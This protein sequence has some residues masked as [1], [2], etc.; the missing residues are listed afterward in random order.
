MSDTHYLAFR[1]V[2]RTFE[3]TTSFGHVVH[4]LT[5]AGEATRVTGATVT[6]QFLDVLRTH[7]VLGRS[8]VA[9]DATPGN[10]PIVLLSDRLWRSRFGADPQVLHR[11]IV[12]DGTA[13]TVVGILPRGFSFPADAEFWT[14][15][16]IRPDPNLT[17]TRPVIGRLRSGVTHEQAA[18]AFRA[19]VAQLPDPGSRENWRAEVLRLR[20]AVVGDTRQVLFLFAGAV[21]CVLLITWANVANLLLMRTLSRRREIATRFALGASYARI[22]RLMLSES[23]LVALAGGGLGALVAFWTVPAILSAVPAGQLPRIAEVRVDG[24]VGLF[25]LGLSLL[26]GVFLGL[27]SAHQATR[28]CLAGFPRESLTAT[29]TRARRV[30]NALV[31]GEIA[32][33][34]VLLIGAGLLAKSFLRLRSIDPGFQVDRVMT[35]TVELTESRYPTVVASGEFHDRLLSALRRLPQITTV[36]AINWLPLGD[37]LLRGDILL[38]GGRTVPEDYAVTKATISPGYFGTMG[39]PLRSGRDFTDADAA[40]APGVVIVSRA[41]ARTLWPNEE[42]LGRNLSVETPPRAPIWLTVVGVVDD[43]RQGGLKEST[44]PAIYQPYRQAT[45][46]RF[47]DYM[48]FVAR[49]SGDPGD[50]A[51][52]MRGAL[53]V[54]DRDLAPRSQA[55]LEDLLAVSLAEPR[56]QSS[57]VGLFSL[58]ALVLAVIGIYGVLSY[59]VEERQREIGIRVALGATPPAVVR[60]VLGQTLAVAGLG[61]GLGALGAL[62]LRRILS[63]FLFDVTPTDAT[64]FVGACVA[65]VIAALVAGLLPARRASGVDPLIVLKE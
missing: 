6:P 56:F 9:D 29:S 33:A 43:V 45:R 47:L 32:V 26:T 4:T 41:V 22:A 48:T 7:P 25:T 35:M 23:V 2:D 61:V 51:R 55:A 59:A 49:S 3:A 53:A 31:V 52:T 17:F 65:F 11:T 28:E 16:D 37:M 46:R 40:G 30:R 1:E 54:V 36:A 42:P 5:G 57:V 63:T 27:A 21:G 18:A 38:D 44:L 60:M 20:Q 14:L 13:H 8:F 58:V 24:W 39:I 62:A 34:M 12:L 10:P 15:L 64:T 19:F 50:V